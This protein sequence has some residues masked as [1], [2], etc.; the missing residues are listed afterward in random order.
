MIKQ[1][2][3]CENKNDFASGFLFD[4]HSLA[5]LMERVK[6]TSLD[7]SH[8]LILADTVAELYLQLLRYLARSMPCLIIDNFDNNRLGLSQVQCVF[9]FYFCHPLFLSS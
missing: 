8:I 1:N 5:F 6:Q 2:H 4:W 7:S 3:F 9:G